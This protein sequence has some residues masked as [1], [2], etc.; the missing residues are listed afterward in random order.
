[1]YNRQGYLGP[2]EPL[3]VI[4]PEYAMC[5]AFFC[6]VANYTKWAFWAWQAAGIHRYTKGT[7]S[8][9]P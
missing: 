5:S 7:P 4:K 9:T 2:G 1:M 3:Q 6:V 8:K